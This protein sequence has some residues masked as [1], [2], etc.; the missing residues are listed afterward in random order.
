MAEVK[1]YTKIY[2][3]KKLISFMEDENI[4]KPDT[5]KEEVKEDSVEGIS[6]VDEA[7]A[8]RDEIKKERESLKEENDRK[9]K[10]QA[11]ELLGSSAGG[12]IEPKVIPPEELKKAQAKDFFK[13]TE[14]ERAIE[15]L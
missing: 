11:E 9:Q 13:G 8:I 12:R 3:P 14:L 2:K 15:K 10:L 4:K 6:I 1:S 5:E 7:R